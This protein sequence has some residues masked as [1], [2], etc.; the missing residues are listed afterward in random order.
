MS[1]RYAGP[2]AY[3]CCKGC[4]TRQ[5]I[6][7]GA[8]CCPTDGHG[9][10]ARV[11]YAHDTPEWSGCWACAQKRIA[12]KSVDTTRKEA[13]EMQ[14]SDDPSDAARRRQIESQLV[15]WQAKYDELRE[16]ITD[17]CCSNCCDIVKLHCDV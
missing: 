17:G 3:V 5:C 6:D 11:E 12:R 16:L 1:T 15:Y 10:Y 13:D 4:L 8:Q 7:C 2:G 9:E 14:Q